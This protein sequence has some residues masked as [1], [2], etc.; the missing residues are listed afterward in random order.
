ML[1]VFVT[2]IHMVEQIVFAAW[3]LAV[4]TTVLWCVKD[5]STGQSE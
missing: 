2:C 4:I 3:G 5:D 1:A